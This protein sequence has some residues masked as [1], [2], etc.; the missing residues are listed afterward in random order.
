MPHESYTQGRII[1]ALEARGAYVRKQHQ[2][3]YTPSGTPDLL[4]GYRGSFIGMEVKNENIKDPQRALSLEQLSNA[5]EIQ[6][7]GCLFYVVNSVKQAIAVLQD[8]DR[9]LDE[10]K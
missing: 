6:A 3:G 2:S 9:L 10:E 5:H 1:R 7:A 8:I 4:I